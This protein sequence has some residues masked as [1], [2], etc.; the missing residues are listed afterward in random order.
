MSDSSRS[1][2]ENSVAEAAPPRTGSRGG[3]MRALFVVNG[4]VCCVLIT[5]LVV[6]GLRNKST[7]EEAGS[8]GNGPAAADGSLSKPLAS[9][10]DSVE[11]DDDDGKPKVLKIEMK[12]SEE[13]IADFEFTERSG[14]AIGK[15]DL[16]G[17]PWIAGFIFT[18][19]AGPCFKVSAAM[20]RLQ[21]EFCKNTD[22]RLVSFTV[23][24]E[25][26]RPEVLTKYA[27]GF[28]ADSDRWL[29]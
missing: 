29:F 16:L 10:T 12:W 15:K 7:S 20:R 1:S 5:A 3:A 28:D 22:L 17:H 21:D 26:D 8:G 13:G 27:N 11:A 14:R 24:P 4:V 18:N 2:E 6:F 25:R 9:A 19:C 23:D